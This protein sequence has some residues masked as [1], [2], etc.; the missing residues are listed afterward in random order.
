M[1]RAF[2]TPPHVPWMDGSSDVR[3]G[4]RRHYSSLFRKMSHECAMQL[5]MKVQQELCLKGQLLIA[6][7]QNLDRV[8]MLMRGTL[9]V[10]DNTGG[11]GGGNS[12]KRCGGKMAKFCGGTT[13]TGGE[14][15]TSRKSKLGLGGGEYLLEK[16]GSCLGAPP[17]FSSRGQR[18]TEHRCPLGGEHI[19]SS[20]PPIYPF[21]VTAKAKVELLSIKVKEI[22]GILSIF[23]EDAEPCAEQLLSEHKR[24][25]N[26]VN[27][28]K[29]RRSSTPLAGGH[30]D[31]DAVDEGADGAPAAEHDAVKSKREK[32]RRKSEQSL[33][34]TTM[35]MRMTALEEATSKLTTSLNTINKEVRARGRSPPPLSSSLT[36]SC[37][38]HT[39][40]LSHSICRSSRILY[41]FSKSRR[42]AEAQNAPCCQGLRGRTRR[43]RR[44]PSCRRRLPENFSLPSAGKGPRVT[45]DCKLAHLD[46]GRPTQARPD[47]TPPRIASSRG[48]ATLA[49]LVPPQRLLRSSQNLS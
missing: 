30:S 49:C 19:F 5:L 31:G 38:V 44:P 16:P 3:L 45:M 26:A 39:L 36:L 8:Y 37:F 14:A 27:P 13:S 42:P 7:G 47:L 6:E 15:S 35:L 43:L 17:P 33:T 41:M 46:R 25:V 1:R 4:V 12:G 10:K 29:T 21:D 2:C 34:F 23:K 40:S 22:E 32:E 28:E 20:L 24:L 48:C 9:N 18:F 11:D